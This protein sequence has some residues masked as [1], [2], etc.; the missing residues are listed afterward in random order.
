MDCLVIRGFGKKK[1][2]KG[3]EVDF[4]KVDAELISPALKECE[5]T[6]GTTVK[7]VDAGSVH[8]DMFQLILRADIVICDITVHNPNVFY[9][10][11]ARHALR[12]KHTVLIKGKPSADSTP[13]DIAGARYTA[14]DVTDPA[15]A[16]SDLVGVIKAS[17][18]RGRETDSPIFLMMPE[19]PE[20]DVNKVAMVPTAFV[21]EV[22]SAESRADKGW[23]RLLAE[24]VRGELFQREGLK[25]I[26]WA[27]WMLKDYPA[28]I[29]TWETVRRRADLDLDANLAL[30]NLYERLFRDTKDPGQLQYSNQ[31][32]ERVLSRDE[33]SPAVQSE[34]QALKGRNVKTLWRLTFEKLPTLQQRR[35]RGIDLKAVQSYAAYKEAHK[36]DL[37]NFF[38]ALTALQMGHILLSLA[39]MP[40]FRNLFPDERTA[41]RYVEDLN[42]ELPSLR[43]VVG[44]S[45]S[46]ALASKKDKELTWARISDADL[47]FLDHLDA[48]AGT[49]HSI[50]VDAYKNA[51]PEDGAAPPDPSKWKGKSAPR[52]NFFWDA[53]RGQL[54]LF[55]LLGIGAPA[56]REVIEEF[57]GPSSVDVEADPAV[58]QK[59]ERHVVI[60]SGHNIDRTNPAPSRPRF[61]AS[62]QD[63]AR[64]LIMAALQRLKGEAN[65]LSV[66]VSAAPGADILALEACQKLKLAT[67]LCL[68]VRR[69]VVAKDVF[70]DYD[71][72]WRNRFF[73][74]AEALPRDRIFVL[75]EH[76]QLPQWLLARTEM[77]PW[78]RGNR[79]MLRQAQAWGATRITLLALWDHNEADTSPNGTAE[80]IRLA[81]DAGIYIELIDCRPLA[82]G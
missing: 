10:L 1:D 17:Q 24:D 38:P 31:A 45:V 32:I 12:K 72:S 14:Y 3:Q 69:E 4:D 51:V 25:L 7:V 61:P 15:A 27:Q 11:G 78:S 13:F 59:R 47:K 52:D 19:L 39:N 41:R 5:L 56:A 30:A 35:E 65:D 40:R 62:A 36:V 68:P 74:L 22:E 6:G 54:K 58:R 73:L 33:L 23:L 64:E 20:A 79:W 37:N 77:T 67:W 29:D 75:S 42:D 80:M 66:L 50:V 2:A 81:R 44:M 26:G 60:F 71:D 18:A 46:G 82:T 49:D 76:G 57:D 21:E 53:A 9:E 8:K 28:A 63:Q 43:H 34:A 55:E 48:P 16:L 70:V